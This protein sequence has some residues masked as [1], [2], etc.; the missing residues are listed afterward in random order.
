MQLNPTSKKILDNHSGGLDGYDYVAIKNRL[1]D[2]EEE[3]RKLKKYIK[4]LKYNNRLLHT[5]SKWD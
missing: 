1:L 4:N 5:H 3:V 2:L